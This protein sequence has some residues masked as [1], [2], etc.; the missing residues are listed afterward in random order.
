LAAFA[1]NT[2]TWGFGPT[3]YYQHPDTSGNLGQVTFG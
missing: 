2:S 1:N 3:A